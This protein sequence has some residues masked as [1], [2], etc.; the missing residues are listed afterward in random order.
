VFLGSFT[1]TEFLVLFGAAA[2]MV[3]LLYL[4]DR[5]R[6]RQVVASLRFWIA[7]GSPTEVR[8][9]RRIRQ[10]LSLLLL[11]VALLLLIAGAGALSWGSREDASQD[12]VLIVDMS[13]W[14]AASAGEGT[15]M[16]EA[17]SQAL[18]W[19]RALPS[20]DRVM[21]VRAGALATPVT[22]FE[23]DRSKVELAVRA[24]APGSTALA[25]GNALDF[26]R[27]AQ[28]LQATTPGEIVYAGA[29][30]IAA[31]D[32][33]HQQQAPVNL[34]VLHTEAA[35]D[36]VGLLRVGLRHSGT[37]AD[38]WNLYAAVGNYGAVSRNVEVAVRLSG[39]PISGQVLDLE[40]GEEKEATF[41]LRTRAAAE[42]EVRLFSEDGFDADNR[43]VLEVPSTH[44]TRVNVYTRRPEL[45][46]PLVAASPFVEASFHT[47]ESYQQPE[48][49]TIVI[50]DGFSPA[51]PLPGNAIWLEPS[52]ANSPAPSRM[53]ARD[54][55]VT[56]WRSEHPLSR[57][58]QTVDLRL[59]RAT[60]FDPS[61]GWDA[62]A[63]VAEGPVILTRTD[64]EAGKMAVFGFHPG[65]PELRFELAAPLL[66]ANA[67]RWLEPELFPAA[68]LRAGSVGSAEVMLDAA[69][70]PEQVRV[71]TETGATLPSTIRNGRLRFFSARSGVVRISTGDREMVYSMT[72]PEVPSSVW[73]P[74]GT[75]RQGV[76]PA[77]SRAAGSWGLW[78]WL[79]LLAMAVLLWEWLRYGRRRARTR[80]LEPGTG[81]PPT[82]ADN[83][84]F[85]GD[86][87]RRA[88]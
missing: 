75:V 18:G 57:G 86:P 51:G 2:A 10:P 1:L 78:R 60:V 33:V 73:A 4:L 45:L 58:L 34:R 7:A 30:R 54:S 81:S 14:M 61:D 42:V 68:E 80:D 40:P 82:I 44:S 38:V 19:I 47:P 76:P 74:P 28:A 32:P 31:D 59:T 84:A 16:D 13:A 65:L 50:L 23:G 79:A 67:L 9:R 3:T 25:L 83:L 46:R 52:G 48:P 62:V 55:A 29:G 71:V 63:S 24:M 20:G 87:A 85:S 69:T 56:S 37:E 53:I 26:A 11:L 36:N 70:R 77:V 72:L 49:G 6:S 64:A 27:Q 5:A 17:R 21:V 8:R 22:G 66:F 39:S 88:S 41:V 35:V 15:L 43:A 12:H